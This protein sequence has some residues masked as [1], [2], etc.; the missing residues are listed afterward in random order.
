MEIPRPT[1]IVPRGV[2]ADDINEQYVYY[3]D[4]QWMKKV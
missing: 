4:P 1:T 3:G 2:I